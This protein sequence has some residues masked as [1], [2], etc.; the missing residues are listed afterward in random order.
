MEYSLL[1]TSFLFFGATHLQPS[2]QRL[3]DFLFG[4]RVVAEINHWIVFCCF[5]ICFYS[6]S[7]L[8]A[9]D[10]SLTALLMVNSLFL[11]IAL[12]PFVLKRTAPGFVALGVSRFL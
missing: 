4:L 10:G 6:P 9:I 3:K 5:A 2:A 11:A 8:H 1:V 7:G 12:I